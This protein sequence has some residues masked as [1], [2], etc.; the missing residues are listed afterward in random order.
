MEKTTAFNKKLH[1]V[2]ELKSPE[3]TTKLGFCSPNIKTKKGRM[4]MGGIGDSYMSFYKIENE[5]DPK[6]SR[7]PTEP[8]QP[9]LGRESIAEKS[10]VFE[11]LQETIMK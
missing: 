11:S 2:C 4:L 10:E 7:L 9:L 3:A 5:K 1:S 6:T 8:N